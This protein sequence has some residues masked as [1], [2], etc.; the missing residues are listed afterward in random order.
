[1]KGNKIEYVIARPDPSDLQVLL[2]YGAQPTR[3]LAF[4]VDQVK[5]TLTQAIG[6]VLGGMK[7]FFISDL[8]GIVPLRFVSFGY[9]KSANLR[10]QIL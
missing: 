8:I 9:I 3:G 5:R 4:K 7:A 1:L 2:K 6:L 10:F